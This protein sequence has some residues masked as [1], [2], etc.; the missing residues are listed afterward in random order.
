MQAGRAE[1]AQRR[2]ADLQLIGSLHINAVDLPFDGNFILLISSLQ[3]KDPLVIS[4]QTMYR[5]DMPYTALRLG[6]SLGTSAKVVSGKD[7][8]QQSFTNNIPHNTT[9]REKRC[10][11][12]PVLHVV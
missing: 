1:Q 10:Y 8:S 9:R 4:I 12:L 3:A 6:Y 11:L 5:S 7:D 2:E